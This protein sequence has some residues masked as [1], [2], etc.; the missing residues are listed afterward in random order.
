MT[1]CAFSIPAY[2][3]IQ[4]YVHVLRKSPLRLPSPPPRMSL[5]ARLPWPSHFIPTVASLCKAPL[6]KTLVHFEAKA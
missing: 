3:L 2:S 5:P 1:R 4:K 6:R